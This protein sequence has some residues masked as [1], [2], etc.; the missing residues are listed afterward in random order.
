MSFVDMVQDRLV[1]LYLE[2][3]CPVVMLVVVFRVRTS[4]ALSPIPTIVMW[5][6]ANKHML[7]L[8]VHK[9]SLV[10]D[11]AEGDYEVKVTLNV[12]IEF[13]LLECISLGLVR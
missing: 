3:N 13:S 4:T 9:L 7:E 6:F 2:F 1:S 5:Q 12:L 10:L 11:I 8:D